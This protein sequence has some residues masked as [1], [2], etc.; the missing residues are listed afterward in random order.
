M[1]NLTLIAS[2]A[3]LIVTVFATLINFLNYKAVMSFFLYIESKTEGPIQCQ[4]LLSIDRISKILSLNDL[5]SQDFNFTY[6]DVYLGN[7]GPGLAKNIKWEVDYCP[8]RNCND[9]KWTKGKEEAFGPHAKKNIVGYLVRDI[10]VSSQKIVN[11]KLPNKNESFP[12]S[13]SI[14]YDKPGI[15]FNQIRIEEKFEISQDGT[16]DRVSKVKS[17]GNFPKKFSFKRKV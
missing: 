5:K 16:V 6:F 15:H 9:L 2:I 7:T 3:V 14:E 12:W 8:D 10:F 13:I 4:G 11:L 17:K 1:C